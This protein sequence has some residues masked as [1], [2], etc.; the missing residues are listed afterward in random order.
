MKELY[1][2]DPVRVERVDR[3]GA[4]MDGRP[5]RLAGA[6]LARDCHDAVI[7]GI[8]DLLE[9]DRKLIEPVASRKVAN[10]DRPGAP[11]HTRCPVEIR[12]DDSLPDA[13]V[14]CST[15]WIASS[16]GLRQHLPCSPHDL[17]VLLRH[18]PL[19]IPLRRAPVS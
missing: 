4:Y 12:C 9:L 8:D 17:D 10:A 14:E 15:G 16:H 5:A 13:L 11:P 1:P 19:S 3:A 18:R 2:N 6:T 7:A